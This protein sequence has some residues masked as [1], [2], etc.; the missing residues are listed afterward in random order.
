ME[1]ANIDPSPV[2]I[3][4]RHEGR[5]MA[6]TAKVAA[7]G[8]SA[9]ST[10]AAPALCAEAAIVAGPIVQVWTLARSRSIED[11]WT[12]DKT[13]MMRMARTTTDTAV[14]RVQGYARGMAPSIQLQDHGSHGRNA[15]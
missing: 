12:R 8:P 6:L 1:S 7:T 2:L 4:D 15:V 3:L 9:Q 11:L 14:V 13:T 10:V 5:H